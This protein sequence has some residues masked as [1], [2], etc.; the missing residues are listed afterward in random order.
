[1][2][3]VDFS[4]FFWLIYYISGNLHWRSVFC[5]Y[6]VIIMFADRFERREDL[7]KSTRIFFGFRQKQESMKKVDDFWNNPLWEMDVLWN[8][9]TEEQK[10]DKKC[11]WNYHAYNVRYLGW[12]EKIKK[13]RKFFVKIV[14]VSFC[15]TEYWGQ[16]LS[17]L[18]STLL[19]MTLKVPLMANLVT[20]FSVTYI[21]PFSSGVFLC[22]T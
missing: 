2:L 13:N 11:W 20:V 10:Q 4:I 16:T 15:V 8:K 19:W 22:T 6:Q 14:D 17:T 9:C 18:N 12:K 21:Y 5:E 3:T 7:V 1:M